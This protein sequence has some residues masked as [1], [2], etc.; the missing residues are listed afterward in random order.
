MSLASLT[1]RDRHRF[2]YGTRIV[3]FA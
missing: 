1:Q 2:S 3:C